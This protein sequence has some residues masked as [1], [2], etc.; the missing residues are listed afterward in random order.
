MMVVAVMVVVAGQRVEVDE[1]YHCVRPLGLCFAIEQ[2][3]RL[4]LAVVVVVVVVVAVAV[5]VV[6]S[7]AWIDR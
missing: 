2:T 7:I 1:G 3:H 5:A 6:M 4:L